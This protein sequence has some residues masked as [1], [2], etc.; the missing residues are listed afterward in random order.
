M[1]VLLISHS[2]EENSRE[3]YGPNIP[4][5]LGL[6]YIASFLET[7]GHEIDILW[8]DTFEFSYA[9]KL[10]LSKI[11]ESKPE[12][13]GIQ[14]FSMNRVSSYRLIE[15]C[16]E[17]YPTL[18]LVIG[19]IHASIMADQIVERYRNIIIV[20]GEGEVAFSELLFAFEN[21]LS[22][23]NIKGLVYWDNGE[24]VKTEE[25]ELNYNLDILPHPKHEVFFDSEPKRTEAHIITSRGCPF[26]CSFCCLHIISKRKHR[27][28]NID[29]VI[30]EI[31]SLKIKYP[32]LKR[33]QFHDDT[34]TLD[35]KRVL[36][37]CKKI[38]TLSLD[39]EFIISARVKPVSEEMLYYM[40]RAGFKKLM[41]GLETGAEKLMVNI[42]K[43]INKKDVDELFYK[44]KKHNF[45]I[46]TF[47][48]VGFP[49]ENENTVA[50]TISFVKKLQKIKYNYIVGIGKL[51]VYPGTE[52]Y[53]TMKENNCI[54]DN[55]WLTDE[56]V[57]YFTA[58]LN[59]N[60][61]KKF[62]GK[63]LDHLS[64]SRIF[65]FKGF[66]Y[67]FLSMPLV[68]LKFLMQ[69]KYLI[70]SIIG[71][72]IRINFPWLY[73]KLRKLWFQIRR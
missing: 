36:D 65:T 41:F 44:L 72:K 57:P 33:V 47:L 61:L 31:V 11:D 20:M 30:K 53:Q 13:L 51:W 42:H 46:T 9:Q 24:I 12:V 45:L 15:H 71:E 38:I 1:K 66:I 29:D 32:R 22:L 55:Y 43:G 34:F 70:L 19:G 52:I 73:P 8:L 58:E 6:A 23:N 26:K 69:N 68:I 25:R 17:K 27:V 21:K 5:S 62:E 2:F 60:T 35:N 56:D 59:L 49:G 40:E 54:S 16:S 50:E 39:I 28:R 67:H 10:I 63:M 7:K 3:S 48:M 37:F 64:I 4:Y 14:M 18:K